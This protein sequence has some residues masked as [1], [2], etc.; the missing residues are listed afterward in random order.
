MRTTHT[1]RAL[2][3]LT[4]P[5]L[6][7]TIALNALPN[8]PDDPS[9]G[10]P[11]AQTTSAHSLEE[12]APEPEPEVAAPAPTTRTERLERALVSDGE[13]AARLVGAVSTWGS[14]L[15]DSQVYDIT[16]AIARNARQRGLRPELVAALIA[17]ESSY[18]PRAVSPTNDHGLMQLHGEPVYDPG[19]NIALGCAELAAW[20]AQYDADE[21]EML[22]H[23]NGGNRPP[24]C[25][26][27][28]ADRILRLAEQVAH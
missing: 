10:P 12:P 25:S 14:H 18:D 24:A 2:T 17:V 8:R 11:P 7:L 5:A 13:T 19:K 6:A 26:W 1:L 3:G 15:S 4:L 27:E 28:Y 21:R 23:Y 16:L 22:A 9:D 20:R